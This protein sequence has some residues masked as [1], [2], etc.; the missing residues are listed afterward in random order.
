[1][2]DGVEVSGGDGDLDD[3]IKQLKRFENFVVL[4][5]WQDVGGT[6]LTVIDIATF[7]EF[8]TS[9]IP[10][11]P[12]L[13][14]AMDAGQKQIGDA[15]EAAIDFILG[16]GKALVAAERL[17]IFAVSL[18]KKRIV[19]SAAWAVPLQP[20]TRD[21][22]GSSVPLIDTAEM[23]NSVTYTVNEDDSP[24]ASG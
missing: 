24:I 21:A 10:A 7:H 13:S 11:R 16:G 9:T 18:V 20:S 1:M 14:S 3:I 15:F 23:L 6:D 22:K 8:G 12:A 5:G 2:G 17:G 19:D 4:V